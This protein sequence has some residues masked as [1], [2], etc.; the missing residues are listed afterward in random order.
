MMQTDE[1]KIH[2][3]FV[4]LFTCLKHKLMRIKKVERKQNGSWKIDNE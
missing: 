3:A 4:K 2:V 1:S